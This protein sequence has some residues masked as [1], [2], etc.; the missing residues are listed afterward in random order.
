[1]KK[2]FKIVFIL[3][4]GITVSCSNTK[5]II[6]LEH[7]FHNNIWSAFNEVELSSQIED[8]KSPYQIVLEIQLTD[9]FEPTEFSIG[10][11]QSN[12]DG[13]TRYSYHT[14]PVRDIK[15]K[16]INK[17]KGDYYIYRLILNKKTFFN[18]KG[19]YTWTLESVMGKANVRGIHNL[20]LEIIQQ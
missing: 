18:I 17:K 6:K 7:S 9:K 3:L 4:V 5:P 12:D 11:T 20:S 13:E 16:M 10:L 2:V 14:L 15:L 8:I 1:M 19:K